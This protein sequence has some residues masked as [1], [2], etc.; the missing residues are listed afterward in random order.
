MVAH[1]RWLRSGR[2]ETACRTVATTSRSYPNQND[3]SDLAATRGMATE[4]PIAAI[5]LF[6][7][8][9]A[10]PSPTPLMRSLMSTSV[11]S[12]VCDASVGDVVQNI[13]RDGIAQA[14]EIVDQLAA[15]RRQE[16]LVGA[17][18]PG[19]GPALEQSRARPADRAGAPARSVAVPAPR[20]DRP[21]TILPAAA[22]GTVQ[23]TAR[24]W[25]RGPWRGCRCS[26]AAGASFRRVAQ[27]A[28][29]SG[30]VDIGCG[31]PKLS[32]M[33]RILKL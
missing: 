31:V 22:I 2:W 18:I 4:I 20:P 3:P 19:V 7:R 27:P 23:S 5:G 12:V 10:G 21:A 33:F 9:I 11:L 14:V 30:R 6:G 26:C 8:D 32:K 28:G 29:V 15:A 13:G 25:C 17:A 1:L 16:Q 24:A